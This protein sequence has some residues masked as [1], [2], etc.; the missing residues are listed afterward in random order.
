MTDIKIDYVK[1]YRDRHGKPRY[2]FRRK[3]F[4]SVS[5]PAPG[6]AGFL[7]AYEAANTTIAAPSPATSSVVRFLGGS[8]GWG[9]E[10][11]MA[12][13]EYAARAEKTKLTD[14]YI[15]DQLRTSF[16]AG[17]LRDLRDRHVKIIRDDFRQRF[18]TSIADAAIGRISVLWQFADQHL[19]LDLGA[20][21]TVG[22]SRVHKVIKEHQPWPDDVLAAFAAA[23]PGHL[24]LAVM[25]LLYTGQRR[26]DVVRMRWDQFD[27]DTIE[28]LQ[29]KTGAFVAIPC[30]QRLRSILSVLPHRSDFILTGEQ[31]R[32]YKADSL[33]TMICRQLHDIGI[34]GYS[35]HGLRKNAAQA[36]AEAGCSV[37]EIM[38]ITGHR[39]PTMAMHYA[40][41]AEKK[42]LARNAIDRWEAAEVSDLRT[43]AV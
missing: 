3:G 6:S 29:Q 20:N 26:S 27:G 42:K 32:P 5:L 33:G 10:Q 8:L 34:N 18:S 25:L 13:P 35:V 37:S 12:S 30:H 23:A 28:V 36:L 11:F 43:K 17:M 24:R 38:A 39:S 9:V 2:Y 41:R 7:A 22:I 15:F 14:R 21:P 40:K 4:P 16:G 31:G 19:D 1:A